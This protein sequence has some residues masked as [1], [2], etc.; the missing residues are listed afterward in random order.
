M[1]AL[2]WFTLNENYFTGSIPDS[3]TN[4]SNL[5]LFWLSTNHLEGSIPTSIGNF[6]KL[7]SFHV[8]SNQLTGFIPSSFGNMQIVEEIGL[9]SN[10]LSGSIPSELGA[11]QSCERLDFA[12][13]DLTGTIPPSL[14]LLRNLLD[15]DLSDNSLSGGIPSSIGL[16][17]VLERLAFDSNYLT[18][19]VPSMHVLTLEYFFIQGNLLTGQV[20]DTFWDPNDVELRHVDVSDN[21]FS[22]DLPH[23]IFLMPNIKSIALSVNCFSGYI[24]LEICNASSLHALSINGLGAARGCSDAVKSPFSKDVVLFNTLKGSLPECV[25]HLPTLRILHATGSGDSCFVAI[26]FNILNIL[27]LQEM[28]SQDPF[29]TLPRIPR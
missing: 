17:R 28:A 9:H 12:R 14:G 26:S 21:L 20:R 10:R 5:E 1:T 25:W 8:F 7:H 4:L 29:Q 23:E 11:L 3:L 22:G 19:T 2:S 16:M 15:I 27:L 6:V 13:N 18:G 24:P